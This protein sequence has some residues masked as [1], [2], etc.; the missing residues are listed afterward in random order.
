MSNKK[1]AIVGARGIANYGGFETFASELAPGLVKKGFDV[2]CTCERNDEM[3]E[4]YKG[5][6]LIYFPIEMPSNYQLRKIVEFF[7]D[8][9][10]GVI[11]SFRCDVVYFLGFSANIFTFFPRI[12]GKKSFVNMAGVEWERSKFS[13]NERK[14][15]KLFFKLA[16]I[17]S[18]HVIIDNKKLINHIDE[19]YHHKAIYIAYGVNEIPEIKWN[20]DTANSYTKIPV[21]SNGYWLAVARLQPDNNIETIL[22]GYMG[23]KSEKP[24]IIIGGFS[25]EDDYEQSL[26]KILKDN[27]DK[28]VIFTGGIYN[29]EHLNMFRQNCFGY[30]HAHSIGGTNPSL[31]EAMI[32]KNII[33][34]HDNEFNREVAGDSAVYFK[35]SQDLKNKIELIDESIN[36]Y[37]KLK[38][39]A[40]NLVK[41]NYSW[42][43]IVYEYINLFQE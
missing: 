37:I 29:Q 23:S 33:I 25:C 12:F 5:A 41:K 38:M 16:V 10:F 43:E 1:I 40:Y 28:K 3:P 7:Y 26:N 14:L 19:K 4:E 18:N 39:K 34:A 24:L 20:Q 30:I 9:C 31:L 15:L 35:D 11:L 2:Y 32:M 27:P 42:N 8:I 22:N 6:K 36:N 21:N 17:G 13:P